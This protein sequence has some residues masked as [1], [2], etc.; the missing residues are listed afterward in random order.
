MV[1]LQNAKLVLLHTWL[2]LLLSQD[3]V[4]TTF[5][6]KRALFAKLGMALSLGKCSVTMMTC[7][8]LD[9]W[10]ALTINTFQAPS[11]ER[12]YN[13]FQP[14]GSYFWTRDNELQHEPSQRR[15][16]M[17]KSIH[18]AR[19]LR[20]LASKL[21]AV[22]AAYQPNG[23]NQ[24]QQRSI[25]FWSGTKRPTPVGNMEQEEHLCPAEAF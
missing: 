24:P 13:H 5:L 16:A 8:S 9:S 4:W 10:S 1:R 17:H 19:K 15:R 14:N 7:I 11:A 22:L 23:W 2:T 21:F 20:V 12:R 3:N 6:C 25:E 18:A